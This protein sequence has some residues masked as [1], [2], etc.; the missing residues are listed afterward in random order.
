[1][2][3]GRTDIVL[4]WESRAMSEQNV[5]V[6]AGS[7][8]AG[9]APALNTYPSMRRVFAYLTSIHGSTLEQRSRQTTLRR[10]DPEAVL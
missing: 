8:P 10:T 7:A 6:P 1:M 4:L 3:D 5:L 2:E 9:S